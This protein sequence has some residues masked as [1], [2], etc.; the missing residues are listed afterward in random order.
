MQSFFCKM[1]RG[2]KDILIT[3]SCLPY[4][5][6]NW[7]LHL[8]PQGGTVELTLWNV[9]LMPKFPSILCGQHDDCAEG[10]STLGE[11]RALLMVEVKGL[12][13]FL[14][15][16]KLTLAFYITFRVPMII[17]AE[18]YGCIYCNII[19]FVHVSMKS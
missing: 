13:F 16:Q 19:L 15:P 12:F 5:F 9:E 10:C 8:I 7:E 3:L 14:L 2:K 17:S 1:K 4:W 18:S 6:F 11:S